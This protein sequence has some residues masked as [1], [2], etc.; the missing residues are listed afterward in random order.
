MDSLFTLDDNFDSLQQKACDFC[1]NQ[2]VSS[3]GLCPDANFL[4]E[5]KP[6]LNETVRRENLCLTALA[7]GGNESPLFPYNQCPLLDSSLNDYVLCYC[8]R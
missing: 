8:E 2:N 4:Q 3:D 6:C 5:G 7:K 1:R